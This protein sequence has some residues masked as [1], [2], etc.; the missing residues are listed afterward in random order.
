MDNLT[1]MKNE[2]QNTEKTPPKREAEEITAKKRRGLL[3]RIGSAFSSAGEARRGDKRAL[4]FDL[5]IFT[6]SLFFARCHVLFSSHPLAIALIAILPVG[7]PVATLGAIVGSLTLGSG[8]VIY[9]VISLIVAFIRVIISGG[10]KSGEGALFSESILL[11]MSASVIGGFVAAVYEVLLSGLSETSILFGLSM[12]LLPPA[13][14]FMFSG[15]F[16]SGITVTELCLGSGNLFSLSGKGEKEKFNLIFFQGSALIFLFFTA[17]SLAEIDIFGISASYIFV[18]LVTL[19]VAKRFGA[20]R[21]LAVGFFSSLGISGVFA[22]SFALAGLG[23]GILFTFGTAYAL[24]FGGVALSLWSAYSS[25]LSGFLSTLPEYLIAAVLSVPLLKNISAER[26]ESEAKAVGTLAEDM[27]GATAL[28][29]RNR[30]SKNLDSLEAS[31]ASLSKILASRTDSARAI[32]AEEYRDIVLSISE[33]FCRG[34]SGA[35][36]CQRENIS[37]TEKNVDSITEKLAKKKKILPEDV[38]TATEFCQNSER[39]ADEINRRVADLESENYRQRQ[40]ESTAEDYEMISRL[41]SEARTTDGLE[42]TLDS[43][44]SKRLLDILPKYGFSDGA[45]RVFGER[46]KHFILAGEDESGEKITSKE[47]K[48]EIERIAGV[49]LAAPEYFRRDKMVLMECGVL[50]KFSVA[51]A[52]ASA[53]GRESSVSGDTVST[54]TTENGYFFAALSDGMGSGER[55]REASAFVTEYLERIL[56]FGASFDTVMYMLNHSLRR[57]RGECSASVDLFEFD[58]YT[59]EATFVK[60]GAAPSYVKRNSSIFR[61]R[62]QTAPIGLMHSIDSE[63]IRVEIK[64]GDYVIMLSDGIFQ[65]QEE[66][67]WLLEALAAPP[68]R[69]LPEYAEYILGLARKNNKGYDDMTVTVLKIS[70]I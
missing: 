67:P 17:L 44:L 28:S 64:D 43:A 68:K 47:L 12:I 3:S 61:I 26:S 16:T 23:A 10:D 7:V 49:R 25:G 11:R 2:T 65:S 5:C 4:I 33:D 18:A 14:T 29:Y 54:F 62:S 51:V 60:S 66:A 31:L 59:A 6:L 27:V 70:E 22:V 39:L 55:A 57:Q 35:E 53:T 30:Y 20:L 46:E 56:S 38:N 42:R 1:E 45:I 8:G 37:P 63:K 32:T 40:R 19:L 69:E 58:L 50:P 21:A 9:A 41:V 34:C 48:E 36:L 13:I 24:I 52:S 15:I